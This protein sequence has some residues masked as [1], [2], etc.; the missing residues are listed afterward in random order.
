MNV[1]RLAAI[2]MHGAR[3]TTRRRRIITAEFAAG[4][5]GAVAFGIWQICAVSSLGGQLFGAWMVGA[6]L[7][8]A[9]L[10]AYAIMLRR[11]GALESELAGTDTGR[12]LRRYGLWQFWA[13]VPL[14]LVGFTVRDIL[15]SSIPR[16]RGA[17]LRDG[18]RLL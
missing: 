2:D 16:Q 8:Y 9:P 4:T 15:S 11:P 3:G 7:N 1:K 6:G 13:V 10:A 17:R 12:E 14:A 5:I 18:R